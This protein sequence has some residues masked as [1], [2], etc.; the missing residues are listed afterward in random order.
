MPKR[1]KKMRSHLRQLRFVHFRV[2]TGEGNPALPAC[3][4]A[5]KA[6]FAYRCQL[7][8]H[9]EK[10]TCGDCLE[11]LQGGEKWAVIG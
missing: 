10:V 11:V 6:T 9:T 5:G 1:T 4:P 8:T 7:S 3:D 2:Q